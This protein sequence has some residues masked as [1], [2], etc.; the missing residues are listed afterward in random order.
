[1]FSDAVTTVV[2]CLS[3]QKDTRNYCESNIQTDAYKIVHRG[4]QV[5]KKKT[6]QCQTDTEYE[7]DAKEVCAED[8][9]SS[10]KLL[11]FLRRAET[12]L[13][14][15]LY[16][17][18]RSKAFKNTVKTSDV[19]LSLQAR[20]C[21]CVRSSDVATYSVTGL[22]WS[23][24]GFTIAVAYPFRSTKYGLLDHESWC[25]HN[26]FVSLWNLSR[27]NIDE[28]IPDSKIDCNG[29][30]MS[31]KFHPSTPSLL[32]VGTFAETYVE[33][34]NLPFPGDLVV[35]NLA[36]ESDTLLAT[37]GCTEGGHT[38][39]INCIEWLCDTGNHYSGERKAISEG[40]RLSITKLVTVGDD[41][42]IICWNLEG[43][44]TSSKLK[45]TKTFQVRNSDQPI[46]RSMENK[47]SYSGLRRS[48]ETG[49]A[50]TE[51]AVSLTTAALS[52]HQPDLMVVGT[53]SG[54]VLM[55]N[56][57]KFCPTELSDQTTRYPS[58][59]Q[60]CLSRQMGPIQTLDW[61]STERN[62]VLS[63]GSGST[64]QLHNTLQTSQSTSVDLGQGNILA[65]QFLQSHPNIVLCTSENGALSVCDLLNEPLENVDASDDPE[66]C[67]GITILNSI[68]PTADFN[69]LQE[70]PAAPMITLCCNR[71]S[72]NLVATGDTDGCVRIWTLSGPSVQSTVQSGKLVLD[73]LLK[74]T[75]NLQ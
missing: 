34:G 32:A 7:S 9:L 54:G 70:R 40:H 29:C 31:V 59:V 13:T 12:L 49:T 65:A 30:A 23:C 71:K 55:C 16:K 51:H 22:S 42:R 27:E 3:E 20:H 73:R 14:E 66:T 39:S 11:D 41:G 43:S 72:P 26:G 46:P 62:L 24:T 2:N 47:V 74:R 58:P 8:E 37:A 5:G 19:S 75:I 61:S 69:N 44:H 56:L 50:H 68:I 36:K 64:I 25:I 10:A 53:G 35:Y 17:N 15:C 18:S 6:V 38:E 48:T 52:P 21:L 28:S 57:S 33:G 63:C 4:L 67:N 45:C 60:F 1:M